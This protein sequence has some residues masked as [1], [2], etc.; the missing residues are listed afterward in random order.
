MTTPASRRAFLRMSAGLGAVTGAFTP[1]AMQLA[2]LNAA[3]AQSASG[4]RALVCIFLFGGN[5]SHN[6][7]LAT[8]ADSWG[9]YW[10]AR[11]TGSDPIALMPA[12]TPVTPLGQTSPVTGRVS[13]RARPEF[14]GGVL[15][16][17]PRTAN[18][19]PAGTNA[20]A[21]TFGLHPMLAPLLPAWTA[22]R[23]GVV[24]N[25]GTLVRPITK[26]Q[27]IGRTVPAPANLYSHNDQQSMWQ[28]GATEGAR[29]GWGGLLGDVVYQQNGQNSVFT[30]ISTAGNAVFLSG[31]RVVQYQVSTGATP[32]ARI[33]STTG[34]TLFGSN[35]GPARTSAII[36]DTG[37]TSLF[38]NDHASVVQRSMNATD[39]L[40]AAF[41]SAAATAIPAPPTYTNP[42]SGATETN[43]LASQLQTVARMIASNATLGMQRQ[44]FFVSIGG[45]DTHDVQNSTQPALL[46]RVAHAMAYFDSILGNVG[47]VDMR[48]N[49]TTFTASDFSRTFTSN[50][51]GT[52]HAWGAHHFVMGGAVR[53]GD[54]FGQYPTIGVDQGTF[55]N[56]D[57]VSNV[58]VPTTSV[59]QYGATLGRWLGVSDSDLNLIFPNLPNFTPRLLSF[60]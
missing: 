59:D 46:A 18:P 56:P 13:A 39:V 48:G 19:V 42:I 11:N 29:R 60:I 54:M 41:T 28:A 22:G 36:R 43:A 16:I 47:G 27:Y 32:A 44:V 2:A 8:D 57:G 9:R 33:N 40:N 5:D 58:I 6:T 15:P 49:V 1:F 53:G 30:A 31:Q 23:L 24:A 52:D 26:A 14:W 21:R 17:A 12:G 4:Y 10:S 38:A 7:V 51:D 50:G 3:S 45:W 55:R 37:A 35:V 25:V 34:T 20:T